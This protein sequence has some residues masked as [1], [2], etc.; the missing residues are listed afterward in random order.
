MFARAKLEQQR[1]WLEE[2]VDI[3]NEPEIGFE[4]IREHSQKNGRTEGQ[5]GTRGSQEAGL[6][7]AGAHGRIT[8]HESD[9]YFPDSFFEIRLCG[10]GATRRLRAAP[11]LLIF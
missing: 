1:Y 9:R 4:E 3:A 8:K 7:P 10:C 6:W 11:V 2:T 5:K